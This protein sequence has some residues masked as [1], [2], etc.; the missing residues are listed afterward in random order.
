MV[1]ILLTRPEAASG[2]FSAQL[3]QAD[4]MLPV[5]HAPLL[6][7]ELGHSPVLRP[8]AA[9][10]FTSRHGVA[11][12]PEGAGRLA[13][14]VGQVTAEQAKAAGYCLA[15]VAPDAE[16]LFQR[17]M[18]DFRDASTQDDA[19]TFPALL[20]HLHGR[21]TRGDLAARLTQAGVPT[22]A[23]VVYEQ[24]AQRLTEAAEKLLKSREMVIIPVFSPR[25]AHLFAAECQR[26]PASASLCVAAFSPAVAAAL[27]EVSV[28]RME[29]AKQPDAG[30]MIAAVQRLIAAVQLL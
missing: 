9:V 24:V 22:E 14:V 16:T 15:V 30:N 10:I 28:T 6:R 26:V 2:R 20:C 29:V 12:A 3:Q 17:I 4:V 11:A 19:K 21:H 27:S 18:A 5:V 13:Y 8:E 25:T 7:I 23:H 1:Q